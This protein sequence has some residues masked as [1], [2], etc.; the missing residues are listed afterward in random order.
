MKPYGVRIIEGPN[1]ADIREMGSNSRTG[2]LSGRSGDNRPY[3]RGNSK[4][5]TRRYWKRR[6]RRTNRE[7]CNEGSE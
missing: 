7:A 2:K 6:A 5:R 3:S 1:V 4:R